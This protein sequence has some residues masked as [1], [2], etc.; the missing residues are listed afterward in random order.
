MKNA[1]RGVIFLVIVMLSTSILYGQDLSTYR[2]FALGTT[3]AD[4]IHQVD[5]APADLKTIHERPALIQEL[6]WTP[7]LARDTTVATDPVDEILF[8]F[9]NGTLY[10]ITVSYNATATEG[11][12]PADMV[13]ALSAEYGKPTTPVARIAFPTSK[14]GSDSPEKVIARWQ[15]AQH[16]FDLFRASLLNTYGLVIYTKQLDAQAATSIVKAAELER[17]AAPQTQA[18]LLK[19]DAADLEAKRQ[20]NKKNFHP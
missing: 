8:S 12:T 2:N 20:I 7:T 5:V 18:A 16:S 4:L 6:T 1:S 11:M 17:L 19:K 13:D 3:S 9:Y 14:Y 10:R 15:D